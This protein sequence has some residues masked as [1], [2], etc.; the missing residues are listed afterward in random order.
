MRQNLLDTQCFARL[1]VRKR[2]ITGISTV[3]VMRDH[4]DQPLACL[5]CLQA[6]L[7]QSSSVRLVTDLS[8]VFADNSEHHAGGACW[9]GHQ[10][11]FH[12]G[13]SLPLCSGGRCLGTR[14]SRTPL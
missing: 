4:F 5:Q 14:L 9:A 11:E 1:G 12:C 13:W 2:Y 8:C 10:E 7:K 3:R 6:L